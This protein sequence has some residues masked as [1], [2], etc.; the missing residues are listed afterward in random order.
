VDNAPR[1]LVNLILHPHGVVEIVLDRP[2]ALNALSVE[3]AR[4]ISSIVQFASEHSPTVILITS[5]CEQAFCVGADLK[6][7]QTMTATELLDCRPIF[8][9]AYRSLLH[10]EAPVVAAVNGFAVGGGLELALTCD[11]IVADETTV[12]GL[13]EVTIGLIPGGGG[14]QLL[15]RRTGWGTAADLI[16]TGRRV[17]FEEAHRLGIVDRVVKGSIRAAALELSTQIAGGS[18]AAL[19]KAK[20]ALREGWNLDL[21]LGL[22]L[23]DALWQNLASSEDREE[24]IRAFVEKRSPVWP[25][26]AVSTM[27]AR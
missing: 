13:P 22:D 16:F 14:S 11:L 23:E 4:Q 27:D 6:E 8:L 26:A 19:R 18:P 7:R 9:S 25:S 20:R 1:N 2:E 10:V 21:T 24:G 5:N 3:F 12:V 17:G 15:G